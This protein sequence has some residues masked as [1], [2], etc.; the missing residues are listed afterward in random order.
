MIRTLWTIGHSTRSLEQFTALLA[1]HRIEAIADVRRY[2]GSR[3]W[4][5][6]HSS[7]LKTELESR[8][9][10]YVWIPKLGGRRLP[11]P[12]SV[13]TAWRSASFHGYADHM[14]TEE[15][16]GGLLELLSLAYGSRTAVMCAEAVWWRCHRQLIADVAQWLGFRVQHIMSSTALVNHPY[17]SAAQVGERLTYHAKHDPPS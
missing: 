10:D 11:K 9:L 15:F 3:R 17:T 1:A 4:P 8:G 7:E 2:P 6:F 13:N 16:A 14:E 12:D 5:Q